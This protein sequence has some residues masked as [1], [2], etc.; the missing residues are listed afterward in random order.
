MN[1]YGSQKQ[2]H[3]PTLQTFQYLAFVIVKEEYVSKE[4]VSCVSKRWSRWTELSGVICDKKIL[5]QIKVL[6]YQTVV[7]PPLLHGY[8]RW[9]LSPR[10]E[11]QLAIMEINMVRWGM[12]VSFQEHRRNDDILNDADVESIES[13]ITFVFDL[14]IFKP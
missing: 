11:I 1:T 10:N 5:Q 7:R 4:V 13:I 9:P 8:V 12:G 3:L 14:F 6:L 2:V